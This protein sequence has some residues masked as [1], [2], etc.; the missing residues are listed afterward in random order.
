MPV[1]GSASTPR[2]ETAELAVG[3][4][5]LCGFTRLSRRLSSTGLDRLLDRF[6]ALTAETV[7]EAGARLVK[8]IGDE[9][10]FA[11][12]DAAAAASIAL[13]L[14]TR[15]AADDV[16]PGLRVGVS[17]GRVL[18]RRGDCFGTTVN[19]ASRIVSTARCGTAL[20]DDQFRRALPAECADVACL[21][22]GI[23]ELK[24]FDAVPL[25]RIEPAMSR[26]V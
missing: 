22:Y 14:A 24:D 11:T 12:A 8:L 21:P 4:A 1:L 25:W 10:M 9:V 2:T 26:A 17:Y 3:F 6:E 5:D 23:F 13:N 16:L 20:V 15:A 19:L 18:V 7:G